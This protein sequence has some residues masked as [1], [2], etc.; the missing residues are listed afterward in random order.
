VALSGVM[1][2]IELK[3]GRNNNQFM[4]L[5]Q[6]RELKSKETSVD[7]HESHCDGQHMDGRDNLV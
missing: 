3:K 6:Y 1:Q 5:T 2:S 4:S 7:Q